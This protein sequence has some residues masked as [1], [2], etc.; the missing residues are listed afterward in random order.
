MFIDESRTS[1]GVGFLALQD[2]GWKKEGMPG[3]DTRSL[4]GAVRVTKR[5]RGLDEMGEYQFADDSLGDVI[6]SFLWES[7]D[8]D[9]KGGAANS[10]EI[11]GWRMTPWPVR[12]TPEGGRFP[13]S[14]RRDL[15]VDYD[16]DRIA[17]LP[18]YEWDAAQF[19][20]G[21]ATIDDRFLERVVQV[22]QQGIPWPSAL[23]PKPWLD[24]YGIAVS[25]DNESRQDELFLQTDPRLVAVNFGG[26]PQMGSLVCD[27]Q[28]DCT[29]AKVAPLQSAFRVAT[30]MRGCVKSGPFLAWQIGMS[31]CEDTLGG[32][33]W[34]TTIGGFLG[35]NL[36][37]GP[38][39]CGDEG[40]KHKVG[41]TDIGSVNSAHISCNAYF[42]KDSDYDAPLKFD[43]RWEG[44]RAGPV[45]VEVFLEYDDEL[46]HPHVCGEKDGMWRWRAATFI[47][48][49]TTDIPGPTW[50]DF[51]PQPGGDLPLWSSHEP[52]IGQPRPR[53]A[54]WGQAIT[55]LGM[56]GLVFQPQFFKDGAPDFRTWGNPSRE[57]I[58]RQK[59]D[60][61]MTA[62]LEAFA[63]QGTETWDYYNSPASGR[64]PRY[65][66]G[67]ANGGLVF[68]PPQI[69]MDDYVIL[70]A[71]G[72][73]KAYS[74]DHSTASLIISDA[75]RL[76]WGRPSVE[77]D[78]GLKVGFYQKYDAASSLMGVYLQDDTRY[79]Y[80]EA[81]G[82]QR[83]IF[84]QPVEFPGGFNPSGDVTIGGDLTVTGD[85]ALNA[86]LTVTGD[87]TLSADLTVTGAA[88]LS[89]DLTVTGD[90]TLSADLTVTGDAT[91]SADLTVTGATTIDGVASL[92]KEAAQIDGS[93]TIPA[94]TS[95]YMSVKALAP[96][97]SGS[98][99][100]IDTTGV[101]DGQLVILTPYPGHDINIYEYIGYGGN[102]YGSA[103][104]TEN[105][106]LAALIYDS[107]LGGWMVMFSKT[108]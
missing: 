68:T 26:D 52:I 37:S 63:R 47:E 83:I 75:A 70:A 8:D 49:S 104:M 90:A 46:K 79:M 20:E 80:M 39:V 18:L 25:M 94:P 86:D 22:P 31:G 65:P 93:S 66:R 102:I 41:N 55:E 11:P 64:E 17:M 19:G 89:A 2:H 33:L 77:V 78:N 27:L 67:S 38:L 23:F 92:G 100:A 84:D 97:T 5:Y 21:G 72:D 34:D 60:S 103:N 14:A 29:I 3:L 54:T 58:D 36:G 62:R 7:A 30:A 108:G 45:S 6:G 107:T 96:Y 13:E 32:V 101:V 10:R 51:M 61:P 16:R 91:L 12:T 99:Y 48:S 4:I 88:T 44:A 9:P 56:P 28:A 73:P 42:L 74:I 95:T 105:D 24:C 50:I 85:T 69:G 71:D 106:N 53:A 57:L 81:T 15:C 82:S 35:Q 98:M 40:D 43:E 1:R 59:A 76:A 87:A